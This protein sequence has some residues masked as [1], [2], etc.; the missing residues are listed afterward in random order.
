MQINE[1]ENATKSLKLQV[2]E[3]N[4]RFRVV[5]ETGVTL[6]HATFMIFFIYIPT[7]IGIFYASAL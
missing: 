7:N 1:K 4:D 2:K 3:L 6:A 5:D